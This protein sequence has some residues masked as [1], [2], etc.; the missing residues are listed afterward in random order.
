MSPDGG[1]LEGI[2]RCDLLGKSKDGYHFECILLPVG[3]PEMSS[4]L[5]FQLPATCLL[6]LCHHGLE[7]SGTL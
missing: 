5:L 2:R 1:C 3:G 4:Q 6:C 7:P